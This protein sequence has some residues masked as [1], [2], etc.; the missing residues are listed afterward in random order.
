VV[1]LDAARAWID[2]YGAAWVARDPA[3]I[4]D[5]FTAEATYRERR[6]RRPIRTRQAIRDYWQVLVREQQR[7]VT[8]NAEQVMVAGDQAMVQWTAQFVWRPINGLMELDAVARISFADEVNAVGTR[9]ASAFE[10]WIEVRDS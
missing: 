1:T 6:F 7:D 3:L 8:F 2:A 5:L 4:A 9:L 10:E